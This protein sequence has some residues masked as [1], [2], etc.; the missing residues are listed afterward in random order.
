[1]AFKKPNDHFSNTH[2]GL[3]ISSSLKELSP[4]SAKQL[5]FLSSKQE[6][7]NP[8]GAELI[9]LTT[10]LQTPDFF[11]RRGKNT[12]L[13]ADT[14]HLCREVK[15]LAFKHTTHVKASP[16]RTKHR[17]KDNSRTLL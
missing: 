4:Q 17:Q 8:Q 13:F 3:D 11:E 7:R 12:S 15:C 1:M 9:N 6:E 10:A 16:Y 2:P 5:Q 14:V